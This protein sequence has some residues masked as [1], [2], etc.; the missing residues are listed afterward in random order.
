MSA[1]ERAEA[2]PRA[3]AWLWFVTV[4]LFA[5]H[6]AEE[7]LR[8]LPAWAGE[9]APPWIA[10]A[11]SGQAGFGLAVGLLTL[12]AL[13]V[14]VVAAVLRP[15]W[16]TEVLVCFAFVLLVNAASHLALSVLSLSPMPGV[17]TSP[18][19]V[20]LGAYLIM[21][22]PRVRATWPTV[23]ATA[24]VAVLATVGTLVVAGWLVS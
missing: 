2:P 20:L 22:L 10:A 24:L 5:V 19:L 3:L 16:S 13:V 4:A 21:R 1:V 7:Y 23:L 18:L 9:H 8:D 14:A 17:F 11:H 12:A 15:A 6:N